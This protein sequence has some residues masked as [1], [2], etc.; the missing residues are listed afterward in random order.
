[1][2]DMKALADGTVTLTKNDVA[3]LSTQEAAF[4]EAKARTSKVI[5]NNEVSRHALQVNSPIGVDAWKDVD[6]VTIEGNKATDGTSQWNY[7]IASA[8]VFLAA[9]GAMKG[10][11]APNAPKTD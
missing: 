3:F 10:Q 2:A 1:M 4:G 11:N 9:I 5:R 7:P 8:D 6:I